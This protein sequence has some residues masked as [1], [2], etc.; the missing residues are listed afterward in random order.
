MWSAELAGG[1]HLPWRVEAQAP[2][3]WALEMPA[4]REGTGH[5]RPP[6]R[7]EPAPRLGAG[8]MSPGR[9]LS[10]PSGQLGSVVAIL[11]PLSSAVLSS[12]A[13]PDAASPSR[14]RCSFGLVRSTRTPRT[15]RSSAEGSCA[16]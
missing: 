12:G 4:E 2:A 13:M 7:A 8:A 5:G 14:R 3:G 10:A 6:D 1:F 16:W 9:S 11:G 15:G